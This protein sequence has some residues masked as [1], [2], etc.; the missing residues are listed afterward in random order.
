[1]ATTAHTHVCPIN[2][3]AA[4]LPRHRLMCFVH[5]R[6]V[7]LEL[8]ERVLAAWRAYPRD[9]AAYLAARKTAIDAV[10]TQVPA[11]ATAA[12]PAEKG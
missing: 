6:L 11:V 12:T 3:C 2:S 7:P 10:Q 4:V 9:L 5:W 8:Q 1:M